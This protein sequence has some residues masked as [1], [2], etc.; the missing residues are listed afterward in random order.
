[1]AN[2]NLHNS[3]TLLKLK[4]VLAAFAFLI[5]FNSLF[6]GYCID[7]IL[8]T[9]QNTTV[10]K[11]FGGLYEIFTTNYI[12]DESGG[13]EYRPIVKAT[14]AIEYG[15]WGENV[16]LSH[17]I[18]LLL[19][20][21]LIGYIFS[22]ILKIF[23]K[24]Y[25][26]VAFVG[27]L[28]FAAHPIHTE[29][30]DNLKS[31]DELLSCLFSFISL[32]FIIDYYRQGKLLYLLAGLVLFVIAMLSKLTA[33]VFIPV[34]LLT[35]YYI[36]TN[37]KFNFKKLAI[38]GVVM[39]CIVGLYAALAASLLQGLDRKIKYIE[40]PFQ[41]DGLVMQLGSAMNSLG[42]YLRMFFFPYPLRYYYGFNQIPI[43]GFNHPGALL[44][45]MVHIALL[46]Y[47]ARNI[48]KKSFIAFWIFF[49][50]FAIFPFSNIIAQ[51]PGIFGERFAFVAS[52]AFCM[53]AGYA[54]SY[55]AKKWKVLLNKQ[56]FSA[57]AGA[58]ALSMLFVLPYGYYTFVRNFDWKDRFTLI[59]KDIKYLPKSAKANY[60]YALENKVIADESKNKE[61]RAKLYEKALKHFEKA[62]R[63]LADYGSAYYNMGLIHKYYY[64]NT[65]KAYSLFSKA[66]DNDS[67]FI[68]A[69]Y[70]LGLIEGVKGNYTK[71]IGLMHDVLAKRPN[72][73]NAK[74]ELVKC[75]SATGDIP[76]AEKYLKDIEKEDN[77]SYIY[78]I[79][80]G[81]IGL[82]KKDTMQYVVNA[83]KA[84]DKMPE[85]KALAMILVSYYEHKMDIAKSNFFMRKA[86][87]ADSLNSI[88]K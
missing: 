75:Y 5:Y 11:G 19:F 61:E 43:V 30:V 72:A 23:G 10:Q 37:K 79:G 4:L 38:V 44:S 22:V 84:L 67:L 70:E 48:K 88:L 81:F 58:V 78:Y 55:L 24:E 7:D 54:F 36:D 60:M 27:M 21:F 32:S 35:L 26:T 71:T 53:V 6:N 74:F 29:V 17:L 18:N 62:S 80:K 76:A 63:I 77:D 20:A 14:Y 47:A 49:Y 64:N 51:V 1:M 83:E 82:A 68:D 3:Q 33:L 25:T 9:A 41:Y 69:K 86:E 40:N 50:L 66:V 2:N 57:S 85:N 31:R 15:I 59:S 65:D 45:T 42:W 13:Y 56:L 87:K 12:V 16:F 34:T 46:V 73:I 8:V 52:L 28:I 39:V